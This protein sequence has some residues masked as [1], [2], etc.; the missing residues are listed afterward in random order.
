MTA[1]TLVGA[2]SAS[3]TVT[4]RSRPGLG[5]AT[6]CTTVCV[7]TESAAVRCRTGVTSQPALG[8]FGQRWTA[9]NRCPGWLERAARTPRWSEWRRLGPWPRDSRRRR[10]GRRQAATRTA[11][12]ARGPRPPPAPVSRI[13]PETTRVTHRRACSRT[14][15]PERK[16]RH[17]WPMRR[18]HRQSPTHRVR[19]AVTHHQR[20][21]S[22]GT[23]RSSN[24]R[25]RDDSRARE[26]TAGL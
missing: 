23:R 12:C 1:F 17:Y 20:S 26:V 8:G 4:I 7:A 13:H 10:R 19:L 14:E 24:A 9:R 16:A 15:G 6:V 2:C 5:T 18:G 22:T 25:E 11:R 3:V 21:R